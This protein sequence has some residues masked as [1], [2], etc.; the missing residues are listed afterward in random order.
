MQLRA[1]DVLGQFGK[2]AI[3]ELQQALDDE[4]T[5]VRRSIISALGGIGPDAVQALQQALDHQDSQVRWS[6]AHALRKI[7]S[8][9][10]KAILAEYLSHRP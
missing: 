3:P 8:L 4:D 10:A 1:M 6:A 9:E 2:L 7:D 5:E